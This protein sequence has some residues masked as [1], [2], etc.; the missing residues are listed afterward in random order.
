MAKIKCK[1]P[2]G[3]S[4]DSFWKPKWEENRV[5]TAKFLRERGL[6]A[7]YKMQILVHLNSQNME[8]WMCRLC[9]H[10]LNAEYWLHLIAWGG[11]SYSEKTDPP[12]SD[13]KQEIN[14]VLP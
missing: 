4:Q 9:K 2:Y 10:K 8:A 1:H 5:Q 6:N 11:S 7:D 13:Q 12:H 14:F 3:F